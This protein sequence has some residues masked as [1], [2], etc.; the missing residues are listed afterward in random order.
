MKET[1]KDRKKK[2]NCT[3]GLQ[4]YCKHD[5]MKF[6]PNSLCLLNVCL[7]ITKVKRE[8]SG[9]LPVMQL[10]RKGGGFAYMF[11]SHLNRFIVRQVCAGFYH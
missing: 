1:R 11:S 3:V 2:L 4:S 8:K 10:K 6:L 7:R 5:E 9:T